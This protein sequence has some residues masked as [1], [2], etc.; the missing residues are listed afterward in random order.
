MR[1]RNFECSAAQN[2][3]EV[4]LLQVVLNEASWRI[5]FNDPSIR[6]IEFGDAYDNIPPQV[7]PLPGK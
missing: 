6:E 2:S 3:F 5:I 4:V 7:H 1:L